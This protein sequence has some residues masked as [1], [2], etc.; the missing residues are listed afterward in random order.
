MEKLH[1]LSKEDNALRIVEF[2]NPQSLPMMLQQ[3]L[4]LASTEAERDMLL[5]ATL[6]AVSSCLPKLYFRYGPTG[7]K[8][9]A[10]LQT[11][12]LAASARDIQKDG[13]KMDTIMDRARI[14]RK[15]RIW[16]L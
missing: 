5:L 11:F 2:I 1:S 12:I 3:M 14:G 6:T 16:S 10:N 7:K 4:T 13:R 8:Y 9:Y 15:E